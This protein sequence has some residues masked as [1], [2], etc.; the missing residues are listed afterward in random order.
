MATIPTPSQLDI[1]TGNQQTAVEEV[2][3]TKY[4]DAGAWATYGATLLDGF[5]D[6]IKDLLVAAAAHPD[7]SAVSAALA[8]IQMYVASGAFNYVSPDAPTYD[9]VPSYQAQTLGALLPTPAVE[10]ISVG[11]VPSTD[12]IYT[13]S[14][15]TDTLLDNLRS[16]LLAGLTTGSTGLGD[17]E[18]AMF[19]RETARQNDTRTKAFNEITSSFSSR[20]FDM[21][22]GALLAK[23]TEMN[24]E[25]GIRL[26][27]SSSQIMAE[28]A[29]LAVDYNKTILGNAAQL[30]DI[31]SRVFDSKLMRD[32]E[33]AKTKVQYAIE[34]FKETVSVALAKADLNKAA[35]AATLSANQNTVEVFKAEI[36]GQ[37]APMNAISGTNQAK[38][39]AFRAAVD[40][41]SANLTAQTL[42]E[43]L[44]LKGVQANAQIGGT[45]AEIA[46]KEVTM[47]IEDARRQV[48]LE[49]QAL[50][51]LAG[52][53]QQ[54]VAG[55]LNGVSVGTT[56]GF[57]A[58]VSKQY[59]L[60]NTYHDLYKEGDH[61]PIVSIVS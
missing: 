60:N 28:S 50:N 31:V 26:S 7:L 13:N 15:F 2:L 1:A 32:F 51:G 30:L 23:Q 54:I 29:R 48:E 4:A 42:P 10:T 17:A 8:N 5:T 59:S 43:E 53:A 34:G 27:D 20:G 36:D 3:K 56:F 38:A 33:T 9:L 41:A 19:A 16:K 24:N 45:K 6:K 12:I 49:V 37:I 40:A 11:A 58:S 21:P 55:A 39:S 52:G 46:L 61:L 18:T 22:P 25:S 35:I 47:M 57:G 14:S 44:K